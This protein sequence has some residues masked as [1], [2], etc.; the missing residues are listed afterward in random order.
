MP[1]TG[2]IAFPGR[3]AD[4]ELIAHGRIVR[5]PDPQRRAA[6]G[7]IHLR[8]VDVLQGDRKNFDLSLGLR[9]G[10]PAICIGFAPALRLSAF[11]S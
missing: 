7:D 9:G 10:L 1:R 4:I 2:G 3:V 6:V 11:G 8:T 5:A